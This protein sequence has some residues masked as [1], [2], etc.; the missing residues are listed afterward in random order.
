MIIRRL[1]AENILR[2]THLDISFPEKGYILISG[3]NESGKSAII[4]TIC[5][6]LFGRTASLE[7]GQ[8]DKLLHWGTTS[9]S[10]TLDLISNNGQSLTVYR[11]FSRNEAPQARLNSQEN[12]QPLAQGESEVNMAMIQAAGMKFHHFL[13]TLYLSQGAAVGENPEDIVRMIAG[14]DELDT[15]AAHMDNEIRSGREQ[16]SRLTAE[17]DGVTRE[18]TTLNLQ[19]QLLGELQQTSARTLEH[20][21]TLEVYIAHQRRQLQTLRS[22][23]ATAIDHLET[24]IQQG[25]LATLSAWNQ[26]L[27]TLQSS[28]SSLITMNL[29]E[30]A[31]HVN[32]I[33]DM[34][35]RTNENIQT[36]N[37]VVEKIVQD[38]K[39]RS[40]WLSGTDP[41]TLAGKR[42]ALE[43]ES[44]QA[45]HDHDRGIFNLLL[46]AILALPVGGSGLWLH[47]FPNDPR[48]Q[49]VAELLAGIVSQPETFY[50][51]GT[52]GLGGLF[53]LLALV[54]LTQVIKSH[55]T[56][57]LNT[58]ILH[59]LKLRADTEQN[60]IAVIDAGETK[61]L[62]Q[63]IAHLRTLGD[64]VSWN[65]ALQHWV[66]SRGSHLADEKSM[67]A[68]IAGF[69]EHLERLRSMSQAML[70][71]LD[72]KLRQEQAQSDTLAV[73]LT[74]LKQEIDHEQKRHQH[75]QRLSA[76]AQALSRQRA[77]VT[78]NID[79]RVLAKE[80]LVGTIR[81]IALAFSHELKRQIARSAPLFTRGRYHHLRV[82]ENLNLTAFSPGKNDY[83]DMS[84]TSRG[85][86]R[87]LSLALRFALAQAMTARCQAQSQFMILDE[88][89]T[90]YDRDRFME[91]YASLANIS[92]TI[93]QFFICNQSFDQQLIDDA[94]MHIH[95]SL[96]ANP[97]QAMAN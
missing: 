53:L 14:V 61:P 28:L 23:F 93:Q 11:R 34:T 5:L 80:L 70:Q 9:G 39:S 79:V 76:Q 21:N 52:L 77:E 3:D 97:L 42:Q 64:Q 25:Q 19:P 33:W 63:Q 51:H 56:R 68:L 71:R 74:S 13:E 45:A 60:I 91:S 4:E 83:V 55:A 82:D 85:L 8:T 26:N 57:S 66:Q 31:A 49:P 96:N 2:F 18:L 48:I 12:A 6:S 95:C 16:A 38:R 15:L 81:E 59:D 88:P 62:W 92:D 73:T 40:H 65:A 78:Y 20:K 10:V 94:A 89:F 54:G 29:G 35:Q 46:F 43:A 58:Q 22:R 17:H 32:K 67:S 37:S 87:Q 69:D 1:R 7:P 72:D 24:V 75:H 84:E 86:Y 27:K 36:F 50:V 47:F 90:H 30:T 44:L 41:Q